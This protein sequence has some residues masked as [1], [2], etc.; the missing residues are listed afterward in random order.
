MA[1]CYIWRLSVLL[2]LAG[3]AV[4]AMLDVACPIPVDEAYG[5]NAQLN[6]AEP[7][8]E[9]SFQ[10]CSIKGVCKS[11]T[12]AFAPMD[13]RVLIHIQHDD[14]NRGVCIFITG[15]LREDSSCFPHTRVNF[16]QRSVLFR[17]LPEGTYTFRA[18]LRRID[19]EG[20]ATDHSSTIVTATLK[21]N[22]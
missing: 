2:A 6:A 3:I 10:L 19:T 18:V 7:T 16:S 17:N 4:G 5:P 22:E 1:K 9:V 11:G 8:V 20:K 14:T 13:V 15:P 21:G 12:V